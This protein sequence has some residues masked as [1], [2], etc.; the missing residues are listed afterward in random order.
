MKKN[1]K[2]SKENL[3]CECEA[4]GMRCFNRATDKHCR[5]P[6]TKRNIKMYGRELIFADFN[7][8]FTCNACNGSHAHIPK[9]DIWDENKFCKEAGITPRSKIAKQ[10]ARFSHSD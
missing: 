4:D 1:V 2:L 3:F 10:K 8:M 7:I 6:E 9:K 5:F